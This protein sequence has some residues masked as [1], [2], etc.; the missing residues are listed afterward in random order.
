MF[1]DIQLAY[2]DAVARGDAALAERFAA[3]WLWLIET[4][5]APL[6]IAPRSRP[7]K[8]VAVDVTA[9]PLIPA[10]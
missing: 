2:N 3:V 8:S 9:A 10:L 1:H 4:E 5:R 7:T 6:P